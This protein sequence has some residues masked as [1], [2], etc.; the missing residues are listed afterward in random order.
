M[1]QRPNHLPT[2]MLYNLLSFSNHPIAGCLKFFPPAW[3]QI[4]RD[5]W[6]LQVAQSYQIQF[7]CNPVQEHLPVMGY[8]SQENQLLIDQE[9]QELLA[10]QAVHYVPTSR[11]N[12]LGF[13]SSLFIVPKKGGGHRPVINLRPLNSFI[14]YEHFKMESI[15]ML[16]DLLRK[17]DYLV[18][19]DLKDAYLT[20]PIW[21]K[22]QKYLRFLWRDSLL[23]FACLP[24]G[25][26]S[27]PRVFTK[28]L[29]PV[30]S[31]L[32][33]RGIRLIAYLD[34]FLIMA[35]SKQLAL[36]H[37]ATTLNIL[38]G[39]GFVINYQKSL[40]IPSQQ[41]EFLGYMVNSVSMSLSLPKDKLKKVQNHCQ[42]LLDNPVTTVREL[43]KV[44]GL[45]SSSI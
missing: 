39:L 1:T 32:R 3:L 37:A 44:L 30:L 33:Q 41:I 35:E 12:E 28:L 36:Q 18:K 7:I 2:G 42:K 25:L 38:E 4:T 8:T 17:D 43:S 6:V 23:E 5:P 13:I 40:L 19:V 45:L 27:A 26:A 24:F 20:V 15:H 34:D 31:V 22:H 10:K 21:E 14:P 11:Q 29:K 9:V 16:K